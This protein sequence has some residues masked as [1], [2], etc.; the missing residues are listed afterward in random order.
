MTIFVATISLNKVEENV[1]VNDNGLNDEI[2]GAREKRT[3]SSKVKATRKVPVF[4]TSGNRA[5]EYKPKG[6]FLFKKFRI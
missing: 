1:P 4:D 5:T 2:V 6:S 3:P